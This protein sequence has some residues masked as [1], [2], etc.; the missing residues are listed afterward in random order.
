MKHYIKTILLF[1]SSCCFGF[2]ED[3]A[4][5]LECHPL[6]ILR[7]ESE[8]IEKM[9]IA[10]SAEC[11]PITTVAGCVN[12]LSGHFFQVEQDLIGNT[13]DPLRLTRYYDSANSM[14]TFLGTGFGS[15][16]P[17]LASKSQNGIRHNYVL[18]S[19]RDGFLIPYRCKLDDHQYRIDPRLLEKGY[20]NLNGN[21][22]HFDYDE[23]HRLS[24]VWTTN[25]KG[26]MI[27][28][29]NVQY[30][31]E[32]CQ[33]NSSCGYQVNYSQETIN[34]PHSDGPFQTKI[35]NTVKSSQKGDIDYHYPSDRHR[36]FCVE[37][38]SKQHGRRVK[39]HYNKKE[40]V[41]K[42]SEPLGPEGKMI[43]TY[44]FQYEKEYTRVL[45]ALNQLTIY[46]FDSKQRLERIDTHDGLS[47]IRQ[48]V[49]DW[50]KVDGQE[51]WLKAKS[52][53]L[54]G[55]IYYLKTYTYDH[56]G[57]IKRQSLY[58]NLTGEK[59]HKFP[60]SK[61]SEMDRYSVEYDYSQDGYNL[62]IGK[63]TP[64]G[65]TITYDY[66]SGTNL[67]TKELHSYQGKIQERFFWEY[68]VNGQVH[69]S[70]EDDGSSK[71][72]DDLTGVTFRRIKTI[73]AE[74]DSKLPS[75]GKPK[76]MEEFYLDNGELI[77]LKRT[78]LF[79]DAQG[80][81]NGQKVY[82]SQG[83]FCYE[84]SKTYDQRQRLIRESN[85]LNCVKT[86]AY[87]DNNNKK[88]EIHEGS[89][90]IH[91][92]YDLGNRLRRKEE[93]H[94]SGEKFVTDYKYNS[95]NQLKAEIDPY[96]QKTFYKYDRLGRQIQ[97]IKP[98]NEEGKNPTITKEY[99][100]LD[101]VISEKDENGFITKYSYNT[102]GKPT[103][104]TYSDD[105][106]E[107]SIY[108]P[109]GWLKQ[110]W[111]A[112]GT[113]VEYAYDPNGHILKETTK[114]LK[115]ILIKEEEWTYKGPLLQAKKDAMGH[116]ITYYYDKA[117]R[118]IGEI[119]GYKV[120]GYLYDD[121]GRVT[122]ICRALNDREGQCELYEYDWLDRMTAKT[123]QDC[124]GNTYA[125]E[126]YEYDLYD[127]LIKKSVWQ[128]EDKIATTCFH[129]DSDNSLT[130]QEDPFGYRTTY[131]YNH[132]HTNEL[133]QQVQCRAIQDP[134]GRPC[135]EVDNIYHKLTRKDV[136]EGSLRS[137][138]L[139][140][141]PTI[142]TI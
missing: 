130:W 98:I 10:L 54:A 64:E 63:T 138:I 88:E 76:C 57:N 68:D 133:G 101:Q 8:D 24:K 70:I 52:L 105:S 32:G 92:S 14:E 72:V 102:S 40:Q 112:D 84:T 126:T 60:L 96:K 58:G 120:I 51:G 135:L 89:K 25:R 6:A 7:N 77:L 75:F 139:L 125:K 78:E 141:V 22:V 80:N 53:Q 21:N 90:T 49:F 71:E 97:C 44:S 73:E 93:T 117:G 5:Y 122:K 61:K 37:M 48:E 26:K 11:E 34:Y 36:A 65:L 127:N 17:L 108:F 111:N 45:N 134:L 132:K 47:L 41:E 9:D 4:E 18:I 81:E 23:E 116:V 20:T 99:N 140:P 106:I 91:Y 94:Q 110:K 16:Y 129:Y 1:L 114:D 43:D 67:C 137:L 69:I 46:R 118:K 56:N 79:Y 39:V 100:L 30:T 83:T 85:A 104:I 131:H 19:E 87:D 55:E 124:Q 12:V 119:C 27:N 128:T 35:L 59:P 33:I 115:G 31:S 13:I 107:R 28:E 66:L 103:K 15:Q 136:L 29:L 74:Q 38:V 109:C 2:A 62:L 50:S 82:D 113:F 42:I 142:P 123:L 121:F 86:Y 3:T 95:L